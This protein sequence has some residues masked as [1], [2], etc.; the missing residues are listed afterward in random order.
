MR[1]LLVIVAL[2]ILP[3]LYS[4]SADWRNLENAVSEIPDENYADQ[5][6]VVTAQNGDWVCV[7]TT[8][9]GR[10]SQKG[11]H[12]IAVISSDK[13]RTWSNPV[14]I[15]P[16]REL[17]FVA[18][19]A[20]PYITAYGRIYVFYNYNGDSIVTTPHSTML[21]WYCFKYSDDH[22]Q[23]WSER[24]RLP[25]RKIP[26]DYNNV[27]NGE[28]QLFWGVSKPITVGN[29]MYLTF[30]R[31]GQYF[32][33][34]E[35]LYFPSKTVGSNY[36]E[37]GEGWLFKSDNINSERDPTKLRWELLPEGDI[38]IASNAIGLI[39]EEHNTISLG[40][41]DLYCIYRTIDGYVAD[42]YSRDGGKTWTNPK[43]A[44][45]E[46]SGT[47]IIK[48][49]RACPKLFAASNGKYLLWFHN[50]GGRDFAGR[51][52]AWVSGGVLQDGRIEW[53]QPE[54]LLYSLDST[55]NG[56]SYPDFIEDDGKFWVT[57]TQKSVARVHAIDREFLENLWNQHAAKE[58]ATRGLIFESARPGRKARI[59]A[60]PSLKEGGLT[61]DVWLEIQELLPGQLII[62]NRDGNGS[63]FWMSVTPK[64]TI[65]LS[66]SDGRTT[67]S[68]DTDPGVV[69]TGS[70]QHI[71]FVVDGGPNIITSVVNGKLCDGGRYRQ[72][73]WTW[74]NRK[75]ERVEGAKEIRVSPDFRGS[76]R[77]VRIYNR[78][79]TTSEAVGNYRA[80]VE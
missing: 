38:G 44:T 42:A 9:P 52:P 20:S 76:V 2:F 75:L 19:W 54:I 43:P 15:E 28:V 26:I 67:V 73:G 33:H 6:Y 48:N 79:L 51:N 63:G 72:F 32:G 11:Q 65:Q 77:K 58:V 5:P 36:G 50:H 66:I 61:V 39:Q 27:W 10:E 22:G 4:Q 1:S 16:S 3:D 29:S 55:I 69:K 60:L 41:E 62:D 45:Y 17:P 78:Y 71:V 25:L 68:W 74:F 18:S 31:F 80:G 53:S 8:G 7:I 47:Q 46:P 13:G 21:G 34:R 37:F 14:D 57:E 24:Y 40:Q 35:S 70:P 64:R 49:P 56:M 59:P 12:I 23:T 30:S